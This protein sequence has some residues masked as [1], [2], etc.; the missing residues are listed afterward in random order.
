MDIFYQEGL[1]RVGADNKF[2][3]LARL[4]DW[5]PIRRALARTRD[6]STGATGYAPDV[7]VSCTFVRTMGFT[8]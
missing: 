5:S 4:I 3:K 1:S 6:R 7:S 2:V 8:F